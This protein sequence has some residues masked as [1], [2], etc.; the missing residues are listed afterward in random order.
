MELEKPLDISGLIVLACLGDL[1][2]TQN[3]TGRDAR[4]GTNLNECG[5]IVFCE[6]SGNGREVTDLLSS[7]TFGGIT[8]IWSGHWGESRIES[9]LIVCQR[10]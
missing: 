5:L 10:R 1:A 8:P 2:R 9:V 7:M 4:L 3:P 6:D